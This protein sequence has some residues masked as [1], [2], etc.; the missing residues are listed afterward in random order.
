MRLA[1]N[2]VP[3]LYFLA[4]ILPRCAIPRDTCQTLSI[5]HFCATLHLISASITLNMLWVLVAVGPSG[6]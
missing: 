4:E 6:L 1:P 2:A 3:F 5:V